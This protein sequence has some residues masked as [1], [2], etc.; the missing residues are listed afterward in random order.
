MPPERERIN[1]ADDC[2]LAAQ[3]QVDPD[4]MRRVWLAAQDFTAET[5]I[6]VD[7]ISGYRTQRQQRELGRRGRPT[8]PDRVSTHRSC[9]ATGV[10]IQLG[11]LPS[12]LTKSTWGQW[13]FRHGLR[14]GGG[15][16]LLES[17]LPSDWQ[18]VDRGPRLQ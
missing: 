7:I 1:D 10:D 11:L 18:H 14:W 4:T 6:P 12:N 8:A 3:W 5:G 2:Q 15:S 9:P 13:A 16:R 17:G